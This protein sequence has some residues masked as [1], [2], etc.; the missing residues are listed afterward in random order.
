MAQSGMMVR[1]KGISPDDPRII[2]DNAG[3]RKTRPGSRR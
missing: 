3:G 1:V 2:G